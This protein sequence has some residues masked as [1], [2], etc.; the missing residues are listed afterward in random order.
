MLNIATSFLGSLVVFGSLQVFPDLG[1]AI[2]IFED[3]W[4]GKLLKPAF[5]YKYKALKQF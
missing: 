5:P 4:G 1:V 3:L 2:Y